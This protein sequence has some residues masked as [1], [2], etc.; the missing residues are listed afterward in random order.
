MNGEMQINSFEENQTADFE[1]WME[2]MY[3]LIHE[4]RF[5]IFKW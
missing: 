3:Y 4:E 1:Q 2:I 5:I